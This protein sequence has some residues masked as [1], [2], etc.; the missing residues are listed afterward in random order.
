MKGFSFP[1]I[2][3]PNISIPNI[4]ISDK[5]NVGTIKN[6]IS[7]AVPDLSDITKGLNI[8]ETASKML[9]EAM[10][11]GIDLPSELNDLIK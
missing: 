10:E 4:S 5:I 3:I 2:S 9:S 6:A 1:N 8:E 7:S 11:G